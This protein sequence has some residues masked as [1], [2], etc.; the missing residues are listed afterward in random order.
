MTMDTSRPPL[1]ARCLEIRARFAGFAADRLGPTA[2]RE[3]QGHLLSCTGCSEAF[4]ERLLEDVEGG[5]V[6]LLSPP[7]IPP[8]EWYDAHW[9]V[10]S[11]RFGTFWNLVRDGLD[12]GDAQLREWARATRDDIG[13]A[14]DALTSPVPRRVPVKTRGAVRDQERQATA[15]VVSPEGVAHGATVRFT[16][17]D[18]AQITPHGHFCVALSTNAVTHDGRLVIC[19]LALTGGR[20]LSFAGSIAQRPAASARHVRID[21]PGVPGPVGSI[22]PEYVKFAVIAP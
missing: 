6:P 22:P 14:L 1:S 16:L 3:V 2:T 10:R 4:G 5:T 18:P 20:R 15:E 12:S 11:G 9:R 7:R 13:Q 8:L 17:A 21:E 19:T